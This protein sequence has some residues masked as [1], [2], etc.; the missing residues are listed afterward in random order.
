MPSLCSAC[1]TRVTPTCDDFE[2]SFAPTDPQT[3]ARFERLLT[4]NEP[5]RTTDLA[6][7][8]PVVQ[9]TSARLANLDEDI[10]RLQGRLQQLEDERASL[11]QYHT[12]ITGVLSP[13]RRM[14]PEILGE[15]FSWTLPTIREVL[16][17]EN[18]PWVLTHV[19]CG[20]RAV[21]LSI[22]SLW[23]LI[24]IDFSAEQQYPVEIIRTHLER[25]RS[26]K[27]HFFGSEEHDSDAQI[28][29]F[30]LLGE[31]SVRWEELSAQLT[32]DLLPCAVNLDLPSLRRAWV[33]WHSSHSQPPDLESI[34][35]FRTANS[36][37]DIGVFSNFRFIPTH[38]PASHQLTRYDFDAPWETHCELLKL[39]PSLQEAHILRS[40]D[41]DEGWPEPREPISL[42]HLRRLYVNDPVCLDYLRAPVLE[43]IAMETIDT[44]PTEASEFLERFLDRSASS[45]HYL[46]IQG[47]LDVQS[48]AVILQKHPSFTEIAVTDEVESDEDASRKILSN[49]LTLFSISDSTPSTMVFPHITRISYGC[50]SAE[51][52]VYPLFLDMLDSR[53]NLGNRTFNAAEVVF[54]NSC[55][56]TDPQS[57]ARI[58]LLRGDGFEISL[59]SGDAASDRND[60]WLFRTTWA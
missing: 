53:R 40:F 34:D 60:E 43:G 54:L 25:A 4:T 41:V 14:P 49:F 47:L 35:F 50:D 15:I 48:M 33:Q 44:D 46:C 22:P 12:R 38:L 10:S 23:S 29:L 36:L 28:S 13:V 51:S 11:A 5:P 57:M 56:T 19:C 27:I 3:L 21:A 39:L 18:C 17:I 2:R 42:L 16:G 32:A 30:V 7:L 58:E 55:P 8:R 24:T 59:L 6:F 37:V 9:K 20:W 31:H 1:G 52:T 45:P 26:L